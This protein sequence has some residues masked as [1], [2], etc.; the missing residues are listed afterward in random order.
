MILKVICDT[1]I[2]ITVGA[3]FV[4]RNLRMGRGDRRG[5]ARLALFFLV[6]AALKWLF[7]EHHVATFGEIALFLEATGKGL[8]GAGI[9]WLMYI[10]LE[11]FVRRRWPGL[12]TGWS[13]LLSGAYRDSLIGRDL[14]F[15]CG[16]GV[17]WALTLFI[18][19]PLLE[20]FG[21][22]GLR[23]S[24]VGLSF[25]AGGRA[26]IAETAGY[27]LQGIILSLLVGFIFFLVRVLFRSTWAALAAIALLTAIMTGA[28][29]SVAAIPL[30]LPVGV[31]VFL[32]FRLGFLAMATELI[33]CYMLL[34]PPISPQISAWYSWMGLTVL[35]LLLAFV[36]YAFHTSLGGQPMFGR[37]SLE[38]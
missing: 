38:D 17:V 4:R 9:V 36:L 18:Y 15:G 37:A 24:P 34:Y 25:M 8:L 31:G 7:G 12:L 5:A 33:V 23:P 11:P 1:L 21:I 16:A 10:A 27:I 13:R 14:L 28:P 35:A 3:F 6:L 20:W 22:P 32:F 2:V 26:F 29:F 30:L 19:Y